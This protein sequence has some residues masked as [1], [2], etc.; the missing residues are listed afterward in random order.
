VLGP[1]LPFANP[2]MAS[3][4]SS[5]ADSKSMA[6]WLTATPPPAEVGEEGEIVTIVH[7]FGAAGGRVARVI[8]IRPSINI[9]ISPIVT[10]SDDLTTN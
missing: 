2:I 3:I 7:K 1:Q 4:A 10:S 9:S 6:T 8:I 5:T